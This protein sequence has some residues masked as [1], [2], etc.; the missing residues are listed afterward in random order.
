M[1][2]RVYLIVYLINAITVNDVPIE[3][4]K[5]VLEAFS[6]RPVRYPPDKQQYLPLT[7]YSL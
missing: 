7:I 2:M 4:H 5:S 1:I 6:Q 3:E